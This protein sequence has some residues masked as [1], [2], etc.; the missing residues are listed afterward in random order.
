[1]ISPL[2]R[3][4]F[5]IFAIVLFGLLLELFL[6]LTG[7]SKSPIDDFYTDIYDVAYQ[8]VPGATMPMGNNPNY[9]LKVNRHGFRGLEINKE[10]SDNT[11]RILCLG[12][13]TTFGHFLPYEQTYCAKLPALL[14]GKIAGGRRIET[15]NAGI[16]GTAITQQAYLLKNKGLEFKPDMAVLYCVPSM[17]LDLVAI[18]E[19]RARVSQNTDS[20]PD[21]FA[22]FVRKFHSYNLLRKIIKGDV[23]TEALS[24]MQI[25]RSSLKD[26]A[27]LS[28]KR[29]EAY[30]EDLQWFNDIC[31]TNG[32]API[33][34]Q[35]VHAATAQR[36]AQ[37][38]GQPGSQKYT[39]YFK[40]LEAVFL[41]I[42][43]ES[44]KNL[45]AV[46]VNPYDGFVPRVLSETLFF[47][48]G[49]HPNEKGHT[50]LAEMIADKIIERYAKQN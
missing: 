47:D 50:L 49:V 41:R 8:L 21:Q 24:H 2:K 37:S 33:F 39:D 38:S 44:A 1:M 23:K 26:P 25:I 4:G 6:A 12:D 13:S 29:V 31:V 30:T 35:N 28:Q 45:N 3:F 43:F 10:K 20:L 27:Q 36:I 22:H 7:L 32:I 46:A 5:A 9:D 18:H 17:G 15:I 14:Q 34:V 11:F 48:D 16:P 40:S 19:L 42:M